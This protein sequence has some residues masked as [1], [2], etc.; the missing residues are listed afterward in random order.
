M[1]VLKAAR[2]KLYKPVCVF[3]YTSNGQ[4]NRTIL[5]R[6][7]VQYFI[8]QGRFYL[9][10]H[11]VQ[12]AVKITKQ[13]PRNVVTSLPVFGTGHS[14]IFCTYSETMETPSLLILCPMHSSSDWNRLVFHGKGNSIKNDLIL[15]FKGE[16][17]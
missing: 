17:V 4:Y 8:V 2:S 10:L 14:L 16:L 7:T 3:M 12:N 5:Y 15:I 6:T 1:F 9:F 11:K 13:N